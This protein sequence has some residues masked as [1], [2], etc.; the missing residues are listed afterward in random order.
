MGASSSQATGI[1]P[2]VWLIAGYMLQTTG[3]LCL[4]PVGLSMIT[5]LSPGRIVGVMMGAWFLA[6][7]MAQYVAALIAQ[8]TG[9]KGA[10]D[11][12][13]AVP[14]TATVMVYGDVFGAISLIALVI[15]ILM[16]AVSPLLA[17]RMGGVR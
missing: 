12:A 15:G 3:E 16:C 1:V 6:S 17:R 10:E 4:S 7:A 8:L 13:G 5:K 9:V 14:P 11:A 2:L